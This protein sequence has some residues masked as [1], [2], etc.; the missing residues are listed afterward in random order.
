MA[1]KQSITGADALRVLENQS[2]A[3]LKNVR[4]LV[5]QAALADISSYFEGAELGELSP[6][7]SSSLVSAAIA[8]GQWGFNS[9]ANRLITS[10]VHES[11]LETVANEILEIV[12]PLTKILNYARFRVGAVQSYVAQCEVPSFKLQTM[13]ISKADLDQYQKKVS[14]IKKMLLSDA[15]TVLEWIDLVDELCDFLSNSQLENSESND[16]KSSRSKKGTVSTKSISSYSKHWKSYSDEILSIEIGYKWRGFLEDTISTRISDLEG[17]KARSWEMLQKDLSETRSTRR[18]FSAAAKSIKKPSS[19][20]LITEEKDLGGRLLTLTFNSSGIDQDL[21]QATLNSIRG[22][23][24]RTGKKDK[25]SVN[26]KTDSSSL[27][28]DIENPRKED[29]ETIEILLNSHR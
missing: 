27:S 22:Q 24:M 6:S 16:K 29:L 8:G 19:N 7:L 1:T 9:L 3:E 21:I 10:S 14:Q 15:D 23:L 26:M 20:K 25:I 12:S 18:V 5:E 4:L 2:G 11:D 28:I 17:Y 13:L